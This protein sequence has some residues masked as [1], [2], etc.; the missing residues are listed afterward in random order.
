MHIY[1]QPSE[2]DKLGKDLRKLLKGKSCFQI[3]KVDDV[4]LKQIKESLEQGVECYKRLK[5]L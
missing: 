5:F 1:A 4:L 3:K 2:I